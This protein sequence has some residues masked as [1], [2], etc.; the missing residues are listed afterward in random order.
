MKIRSHNIE[1]KDTEKIDSFVVY[2]SEN[3]TFVAVHPDKPISAEGHSAE[4][5]VETAKEM[6]KIY[7]ENQHNAE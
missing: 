5:A 2:N 4:D 3:E 7:D 6:L 1:D